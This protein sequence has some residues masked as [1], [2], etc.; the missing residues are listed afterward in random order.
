MAASTHGSTVSSAQF[1]HI[2]YSSD[3]H[4]SQ[5][6]RSGAGGDAASGTAAQPNI[7]IW[8]TNVC[9]DTCK[10]QFIDFL[11]NSRFTLQDAEMDEARQDWHMP[12]DEPKSLYLVKLEE[13]LHVSTEPY[14][15]LN[16]AHL[17][18]HNV[19]LYTQL[20][21]YPT[22]V[23]QIFDMGAN[24]LF[25]ELYPEQANSIVVSVRPFNGERTYTIRNL[26]ACDIGKL[27]TICG[28]VTRASTL[29]PEMTKAYFKCTVCM[30]TKTVGVEAGR[31]E[32]PQVCVACNSKFCFTIDHN[33][34]TFIDK[35]IVKLQES[36]EDM[37]KGQ[38]PST[39]NLVACTDLVD[40][41]NPGDRIYITGIYRSCPVRIVTRQRK[42]NAVYRTIIDVVHYRRTKKGTL[43]D[44]SSELRLNPERVD[45]L[46]AMAK[47]P[48][49]YNKLADSLCPGI[50]G[51]RDIK[52][53]VLLQLLGGTRK[54]APGRYSDPKLRH[55]RSEINILLCGDP[56]TSKSQ[57]LQYVHKL[58]PRGQYTSGK[59]SSAVGLTAYVTRDLDTKQ[60]V[61]QTGAL[62]MC[63]GGICCIDEFDKMS[64]S[65]R[66]I[67]HEVME[68]QTL[69]IAKAGIVCQLNART[70]V[71]A[72]ANPVS[73]AWD[74]NKTIIDNIKLPD[75]LL[76]RFDLIFLILDPNKTSYD[77]ILAKHLIAYYHTPEE[78]E[79]EFI[80]HDLLKDYIAYSRA[81]MSPSLT[82]DS[83]KKL[84]EKYLILRSHNEKGRVT[85]Y[86]RN[87]ES[88]IRLSEG[89]AKMRFSPIVEFEDIE[90]AYRL[91]QEALKFS[92]TDPS[93]GKIDPKFA[94]IIE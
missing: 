4:S 9:V 79:D 76:S 14:L 52:K 24:E 19:E 59:G 44:E 68:Q 56:G 32:E 38:T 30:F 41:V 86:P 78:N 84:V 71:L 25:E 67:L 22:E 7:V 48:E 43:H 20:I 75:T 81:N 8:G 12:T 5:G 37:P 3:F 45:R 42:I 85:A 40:K 58:V 10:R 93:S 21:N 46:K 63:D 33:R 28:M 6:H 27:V 49:I 60:L 90:E 51:H 82:N 15:T 1:R 64:D 55:F 23:V 69:S 80:T 92:Y 2:E 88:L 89:H 72:A 13:I 26:S 11:K 54:E 18:E 50:Y 65:T 57:I 17:K 16:C 47:D 61:L 74:S 39:I 34:C 66:S 87:L 35:Q 73:S 94:N 36:P 29:I 53:G 31:I 77:E 83:S 62:V 91:T 70:S